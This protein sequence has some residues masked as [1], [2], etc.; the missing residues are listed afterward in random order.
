MNDQPTPGTRASDNFGW[1]AA[2]EREAIRNAKRVTELLADWV[3]LDG[4]LGATGI[5]LRDRL[6]A[7]RDLSQ[8]KSEAETLLGEIAC[9]E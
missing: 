2:A 1:T 7:A 4:R 3:M 8:A 5:P 6:Q 9:A